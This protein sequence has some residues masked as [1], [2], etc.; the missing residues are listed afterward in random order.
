M[1]E[2]LEEEITSSTQARRGGGFRGRGG[3]AAR[4]EVGGFGGFF[5]SFNV[6]FWG[7]WLKLSG[8]IGVLVGL[9]VGRWGAGTKN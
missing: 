2:E 4:S 6:F 9:Y 3:L 5:V 7:R 1:A 8:V